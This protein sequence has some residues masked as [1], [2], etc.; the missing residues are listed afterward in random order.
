LIL[1]D[2]LRAD[3]IAGLGNPNIKTPNIDR[4]VKE[5]TIF[6]NCFIMG[7]NVPAVCT[8]SRTMLMS[9]RT[10]FHLPKDIADSGN[11]PIV[12]VIPTV[13]RAAGYDTYRIGKNGN[14]YK[15][16]ARAYEKSI[17]PPPDIWNWKQ[18]QWY[19]DN[20]IEYLQDTARTNHPFFIELSPSVPHDPLYPNPEDLALYTGN[21]RPPLPPNSAGSHVELF[22]F[23]LQDTN[24]RTY[25][26]PGLG[27]FLWPL[28]QDQMRDVLAYYYA[29]VTTFDREVGRI[30]DE[31]DR[32][33][34]AKNTIVIFSSDN[35]HSFCDHGLIHK[36]SIYD[37]DSK[38][39]L[40]FRGPG[41]PIGQKRDTYVYLSD[42]FPTFCELIGVPIPATVETKSFAQCLTNSTQIHRTN[43][44]GA[45]MKESRSFRNDKYKLI[46]YNVAGT[47]S[48]YTQLFNIKDDPFEKNNIAADL[49][50][51]KLLASLI[52]Q[53]R[54][55]GKDLGDDDTGEMQFWNIWDK[56]H[57]FGP[58]DK[59]QPTV[60]RPRFKEH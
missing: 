20:I 59:Q 51:K 47:D 50:I 31:L 3:C 35:G 9:G 29:L 18:S 40:I 33:G 10:I 16:A 39:P 22:G 7:S 41:I 19:A 28:N 24:I 49:S 45:Y 4:L 21:N 2:D 52:A 32:S 55:T 27:S 1:A 13:M 30:L 36:Q 25:Q 6:T 34:L 60:P 58:E 12:P 14:I 46:L 53:A 15:P 26:V 8:P 5:G 57:D 43:L 42:L 23:W 17:F 54:Q 48:R 37:H 11:K 38:V 44:Y 56:R